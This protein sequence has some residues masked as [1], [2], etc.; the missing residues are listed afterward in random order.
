[1]RRV[2]DDMDDAADDVASLRSC[3]DIIL[4][5]SFRLKMLKFSAI[6]RTK[7]STEPLTQLN[8]TFVISRSLVSRRTPDLHSLVVVFF[9]LLLYAC[10]ALSLSLS[11]SILLL[12]RFGHPTP[13]R[14][15]KLSA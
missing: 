3:K 7:A 4:V 8:L 13:P 11:L 14:S 15:V 1:M 5:F 6:S 9:F 2:F 10:S 12:V